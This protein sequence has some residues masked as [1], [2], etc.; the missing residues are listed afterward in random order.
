MKLPRLS[1]GVSRGSSTLT[2]FVS[3]DRPGILP[4][5][6]DPQENCTRTGPNYPCGDWRHPGRM[7]SS[8][9]DD[10]V[11]ITRRTAC[12]GQLTA[13]ITSGLVAYGAGAACISCV[14]AGTI[15][16]GYTGGAAAAGAA[17]LCV[18]VC[19]IGAAALQQAINN[20]I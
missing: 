16:S 10:P 8:S 5:G 20:C 15:A 11:C 12:R 4:M 9:F 18:G 1:S 7:C 14:A 13:C 19:G 3:D 2:S 6:C 17:A